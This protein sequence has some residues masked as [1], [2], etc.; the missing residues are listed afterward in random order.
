LV[1]VSQRRS[2]VGWVELLVAPDGINVLPVSGAA[3]RVVGSGREGSEVGETLDWV[4]AFQRHKR[5]FFVDA[6]RHL[7]QGTVIIATDAIH[8]VF[9]DDQGSPRRP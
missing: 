5:F 6:A 8:F 4:G 2:D 9:R 3:R 7:S 1:P